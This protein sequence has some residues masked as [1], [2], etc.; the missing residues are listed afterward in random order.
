[1]RKNDRF[2]V[3]IEDIGVGGEGI[4]KAEG[5]T[6]FVKDAIPGDVIRGVVTKANKTYGYGRLLEIL[7]P[8]PDR[9]E[10]LC[11]VA[12]SCGGCQ[13][14][15]IAYE[16]Q[17]ELKKQKVK[18]ALDRIG[19]LSD[20]VIHDTLGCRPPFR[21]R[22][23]S[24]FPVGRD[25]SG[26]LIAGFYA[27]RTHCIVACPDC[28]IGIEENKDIL[29]VVLS[30]MERC[31]IPPYDE[32]SH[33]GTVR[34]V[35]IRKG[36]R[37][38]EIMVSIVINGDEI[39]QQQN[40]VA[41]L[42]ARV[43]AIRDISININKKKTNTILGRGLVQLYGR[44]FITDFIGDIQFRISPLS[45]YQVNPRQTEV[46]YGKALEYAALTGTETVFDLYCGV[47][48]I[49][50]FLA[51]SAGRVYGVEAVPEAIEDARTNAALNGISNVEFFAGR[52][53]DIIPDLYEKRGLAADVV[54]LDP[55]RKGCEE[56]LLETIVRMRPERV[57]YVSCNPATLA[58][59]LKFL[60]AGGF[61]TDEV[62]P[63]DMFAGSVHVEC[64]CLLH[65]T[66]S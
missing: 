3:T 9:V 46:L 29:D 65:R 18:D 34:H 33:S 17:L 23:K 38:G 30:H 32:K 11:P 61:R 22:N 40:L 44:G 10:P 16:K 55:P 64:V 28:K 2:T 6:L 5:Y 47:G 37:T 12:R 8:S 60:A 15:E 41:D 52:A 31:G 36:F 58:R 1:M 48:T 49:S 20:Y 53:E 62:Q 21:Y 26:R 59:D 57:V 19:G 14:Q 39:Q 56:K 42:L 25:K 4:G 24:Q 54:V 66:D 51:R 27:G 45:F 13:I 7:T 50:L 43:P 35:L 63:V